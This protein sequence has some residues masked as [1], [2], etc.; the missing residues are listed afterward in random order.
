ML[1]L[2]WSETLIKYICDKKVYPN[3]NSGNRAREWKWY[4]IYKSFHDNMLLASLV[5]LSH[6]STIETETKPLRESLTFWKY[7]YWPRLCTRFEST[8]SYFYPTEA[9]S[10]RKQR[11]PCKDNKVWA[12]WSCLHFAILPVTYSSQMCSWWLTKSQIISKRSWWS[13][14]QS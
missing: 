13:P 6:N 8:S 10:M 7:H 2:K 5:A 3:I 9:L 1:K 14:E 11:M 12:N 4:K